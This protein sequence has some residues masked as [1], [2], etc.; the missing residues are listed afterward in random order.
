MVPTGQT[1]VAFAINIGASP[2]A[3]TATITASAAGVTR[4]TS[5][6]IGQLAL[7]V[8]L[9]SLPGGLPDTGVVSMPVP[10]PDGGALIALTSSSANATVPATVT[11]PAGATS[12]SFTIATVDAPPTQTATITAT[13]GG[14]SQTATVTVVAYPNVIGVSCSSSTP[15]AGTTVQC[16]GTLGTP[17]SPSGW[18]LALA[19][20]DPSVTAPATVTV[21]PSSLTFQFSLATRTVSSVTAVTV[22]ITDAASGFLLWTLGISVSP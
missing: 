4:T 22:S 10:A 13:Y 9:R 20:S 14:S 8:M 7:S 1:M 16:T 17:S 12:Q 6:T 15:S 19:T 3:L 18:R 21:P 5:L 2:T 11:I